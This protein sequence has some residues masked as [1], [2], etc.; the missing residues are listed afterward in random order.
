MQRPHVLPLRL[1]HDTA[2]CP[3]MVG[4]PQRTPL[5]DRYVDRDT[6]QQPRWREALPFS[7]PPV[8]Y[9]VGAGVF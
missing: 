1:A 7:W 9:G 3:I 5:G 8:A 4:W 6:R 2:V